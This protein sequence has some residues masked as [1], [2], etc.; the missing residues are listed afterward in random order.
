MK[1]GD[2]CFN[3]YFLQ[4]SDAYGAVRELDENGLRRCPFCGQAVCSGYEGS[5]DWALEC[6]GKLA[7]C[8]VS[9]TFWVRCKDENDSEPDEM[10]RRWNTRASDKLCDELMKRLE[11]AEK[12]LQHYTNVVVSVNDPSNFNPTV[13]D[14]G[15]HAREALAEINKE[16]EG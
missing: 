4:I 9:T 11:V 13:S 2:S 1:K 7:P 5:S 15:Y 14:E 8:L 3:L 10:R 6:A 16:M 12:A